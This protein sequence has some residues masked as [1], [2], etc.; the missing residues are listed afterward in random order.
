ML[1]DVYAERQAREA[2]DVP[3]VDEQGKKLTKKQQAAARKKAEAE[4]TKQTQDEGTRI[5]PKVRWT[6]CMLLVC[7]AA[8]LLLESLLLARM[9]M[10]V[11]CLC[12]TKAGKLLRSQPGARCV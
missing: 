10:R 8:H 5:E 3:E 12:L 11:G 7:C 9:L 1:E 6:P 4:R 2:E